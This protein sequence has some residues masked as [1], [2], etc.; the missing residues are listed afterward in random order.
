MQMGLETFL[1]NPWVEVFQEFI[2]RQ[3]T[4]WVSVDILMDLV[5]SYFSLRIYTIGPNQV[6]TFIPLDYGI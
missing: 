4:G 3:V 5:T 1:T 2:S 6:E